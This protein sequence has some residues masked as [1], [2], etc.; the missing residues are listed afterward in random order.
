MP[1]QLSRNKLNILFAATI[2]ISAFL[3]FLIQPMFSKYI[4]PWY[5]GSPTVWTTCMLFYQVL[6]LVGY[7]Y[8]HFLTSRFSFRNQIIIH[9][10]LLLISLLQLPPI[11]S[12]SWREQVG[13]EPVMSI[14]S[15]L[16][17]TL[18]LPYGVLSATSPLLQRWFAH[19]FPKSSP[20]RLYALSNVG[21]LLALLSFPFLI[22]PE[23]TRTVQA[24]LWSFGVGLF[25]VCC[26]GIGALLW[27]DKTN[28]SA[29]FKKSVDTKTHPSL[30]TRFFWIMFPAASSAFLLATT[31]KVCQ[32]IIVIPLFWIFPLVL[33]LLSFIICFEK[34]SWYNRGVFLIAFVLALGAVVWFLK[35]HSQITLLPIITSFPTLLFV[36]CM[37]C[38]GET[39]RLK[40]Q[41]SSLTS[42]YLHIAFGS[43]IGSLF[44]VLLA[45]KI[46]DDYSEYHISIF[47]VTVLLLVVFFTDR[48]SKLYRGKRLW[49]WGLIALFL[50]AAGI[51]FKMGRDESNQNM[52]SMKRNFY[53]MLRIGE[54]DKYGEKLK[55]RIMNHGNILHGMQYL[56]PLFSKLP[57]TYYADEGGL[58]Y[59]FQ[60]YPKPESIRIGAVGLGVGTIA[61]W[62]RPGDYL[63]IYEINP[64]VITLA[65][66]YF[67]Y[68]S[69]AESKLDIVLGDARL[70]L[71]NE[72]SQQFDILVLDAFN[73]DSP[74]VHL[75]TTE[76]FK[77]YQRHIKPDGVIAVH[78]SCRYLDFYPVV[79]KAAE[80]LSVECRM[81]DDENPENDMHRKEST[82][83]LVSSNLELL[84]NQ[85]VLNVTVASPL[86]KEILL[87]TDDYSSI[88]PIF[89]W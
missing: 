87:W 33:Y 72:P 83:V 36:V 39:A 68:L 43:V 8:A 59:C 47:V 48:R 81:I 7:A 54:Y 40:P 60:Y 15:M 16:A 10:L 79:A 18:A 82:W 45:P 52:L 12:E 38:H 35:D 49:A 1:K 17:L 64:D 57:T 88:L 37:I 41:P 24:S 5:G 20:Y 73:S 67:T 46:F 22:E 85:E 4:L 89:E 58:G 53:G 66:E 51:G 34:P 84:D 78:I 80:Q 74:P 42:Y 77:I 14:L 2:F 76:A 75:L 28:I 71:E 19:V 31:N 62:T 69:Q 3:L 9:S 30:L 6:L 11:P 61:A 55:Y 86:T 50:I 26:L 25:A 70:S 27:K 13:S 21:S 44:V 63:R 29:E 32:E 56:N 23:F 65:K